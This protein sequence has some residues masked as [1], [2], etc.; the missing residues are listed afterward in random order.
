MNHFS[1]KDEKLTNSWSCKLKEASFEKRPEFDTKITS[2]KSYVLV[3]SMFNQ[4]WTLLF[5]YLYFNTKWITEKKSP[6]MFICRNKSR[7]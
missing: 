2:G 7:A 5:K 3:L 6:N 4:T 1:I